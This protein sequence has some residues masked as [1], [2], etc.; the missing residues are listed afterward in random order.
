M[1]ED[2]VSSDQID[3]WLSALG[4]EGIEI[5]D[6][7]SQGA[8]LLQGAD[9]KVVD[10]IDEDEKEERGRGRGLRQRLLEDQRPRAHVPAQDGVGLAADARGRG[11]DR[12]ADR[13]RRAPRPADRAQQPHRRRGAPLLGD[14]LKKQKIRVKE[15]VRDIDEED[16]EFDEEWHAERVCKVLDKVR[17]LAKDNEKLVEKLD[18]KGISELKKKKLREGITANKQEMYE[19]LSELRLNKKAVER[20]VAKLKA[21]VVRIEKA[22][23]EVNECER[24]AG[25]SL[26]DL[27]KTIKEIKTT[28]VKAR[29]ITKKLGLTVAEFDEM[30][31]IIKNAAKMIEAVE[32]EAKIAVGDLRTTYQEIHEGERMAERAKS[33]LVEA[34]LRLV[35]SIA[36]KYTN[37][38]LQFL[39]LIQEGNIGLMKA[40]DKFEYKRGYKF[41]TYATVVDPSGHH[42]RDRRSGPHHPHPG[43]HDRDHQQADP[44]LAL[45]G[46]GA[47]PRADPRGDRREDGAARS[48]R[49]ARS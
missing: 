6:S 9:P 28:P 1:P 24:R 40:V 3:D 25:M 48:T 21:L 36:K 45:P 29:A 38:G 15:V 2:I 44:H 12:Q 8:R 46:A 30:D 7:A 35:V 47:R 4:D 32:E 42:P 26:R 23:A 31:R 37:R 27:K 19:E 49:S 10:A 16:A 39:D 33:E 43:A 18:E 20:I 34:N 41:S 17:R 5:V 13:G 11:R 22:E 14:R